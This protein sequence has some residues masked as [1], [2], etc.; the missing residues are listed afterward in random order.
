MVGVDKPEEYR[1][2]K[3]YWSERLCSKIMCNEVEGW[4]F[5]IERK[6]TVFKEFDVVQFRNGYSKTSPV[7][8]LEYKGIE[9]RAGNPEWGAIPDVKY[10]VIKL[11][12]II[13]P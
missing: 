6:S 7:K 2:L 11:G 13:N 8:I 4:L 3:V 1:D 9:I 12:K 5:D 10:F